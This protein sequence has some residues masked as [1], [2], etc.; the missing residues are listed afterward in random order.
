MHW[1]R[2]TWIRSN[3]SHNNMTSQWTKQKSLEFF[4]VF[5]R[6]SN[7][8]C[9]HTVPTGKRKSWWFFDHNICFA[10]ECWI[11]QEKVVSDPIKYFL[12][13][14][15]IRS[16]VFEAAC[17]TEVRLFFALSWLENDQKINSGEVS[18]FENDINFTIIT[19]IEKKNICVLEF[20]WIWFHCWIPLETKATETKGHSPKWILFALW[21]CKTRWKTSTKLIR[22]NKFSRQCCE[23]R[24]W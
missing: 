8:L 19:C 22:R 21:S 13:L 15:S 18:N 1:A 24:F 12:S 20:G 2:A 16:L 6:G 4:W 10:T 3:H 5:L 7:G 9:S 14:F 11:T 23:R 17:L